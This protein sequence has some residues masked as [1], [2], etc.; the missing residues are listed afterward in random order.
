[1]EVNSYWAGPL[2]QLEILCMSSFVQNDIRYNLY[3]HE[4]PAGVP[5]GVSVR[6]AEEIVPAEKVFAYPAGTFN[7]GSISGFSNLFRYSLIHRIGGWWVDADV[8]CLTPF[9]TSAQTLYLRAPSST[10]EFLVASGI[11]K[12]ARGTPVLHECLKIFATKDTTKVLHGETGPKLLTHAVR[13]CGETASVQASSEF[14]PVPWWEY[15]RLFR[16]EELSL[17]GCRTVHFWNAMVTAGALDKNDNFPV[18][19]V[20]ERLKRRYL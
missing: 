17:D 1:M 9:E 7:A 18:N 11:F 20:F 10:D 4:E 19:S 15:E 14:F 5:S 8:C 3:V 12:A 2:S 6:S 16:D 13:T